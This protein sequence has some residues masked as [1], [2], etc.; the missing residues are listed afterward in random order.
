MKLLGSV[1]QALHDHPVIAGPALKGSLAGI[2]LRI[3][4]AVSGD[5][6]ARTLWPL[7][8]KKSFQPSV[9]YQ[10]TPV[11]IQSVQPIRIQRV[12]VQTAAPTLKVSRTDRY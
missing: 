1:M 10:V 12:T 9:C 7:C 4:P 6:D 5:E 8:S 2:E 11:I 3:I